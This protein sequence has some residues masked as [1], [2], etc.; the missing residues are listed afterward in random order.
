MPFRDPKKIRQTLAFEIEGMVPFSIEELIV[1]FL[2]SG[3]TDQ[4]EILATLVTKAYI[5]EYLSMLQPYRIN[6]GILDI[7]CVSTV[8]RLLRQE[9]TTDCGLFLDIGKKRTTMILYLKGKIVLVRTFAFQEKHLPGPD[10]YQHTANNTDR[11][12][13][14]SE[15]FK[16]V[17]KSLCTRVQNT[18]HTF[19]YMHNMPFRI[20]KV[21]FSG[22]SGL[23]PETKAI[24]NRFLDVPAEQIDLSM[25][26]RVHMDENIARTWNP[27]LMSGALSLAL[28]DTKGS[29]GFNF[30]KDEFEIKTGYFGPKMEFRKAAIFLIIILSFLAADMSVDYYFL[31]KKYNDLGQEI[32]GLFRQTF[33]DVKRIVDPLQQ[34]K[35]KIN[36][37]KT[38]TISIPGVNPTDKTL[39][40]LRDI[41]KH[42]PKPMDI[43]ITRMGIDLEKVRISG[44]ADTYST[45]DSMKNALEASTYFSDVTI[46][47]TNLDRAG[48]GVRFE[49]KLTRIS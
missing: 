49:I 26:R 5:S 47:S 16:S 48:K 7:R 12:S 33:P 18:L 11:D 6:P 43:Q 20:E 44:K 32:T 3:Q 37:I 4:S 10:L 22:I 13:E 9:G 27:S 19:G 21:F 30:R 29:Q 25:D 15:I 45:V 23:F 14:I 17:L 35:V 40:L 42:I 24:L 2:I 28:R 31:K 36:E 39:D 1:D 34:A 46:T 8:S 38:S 41:S